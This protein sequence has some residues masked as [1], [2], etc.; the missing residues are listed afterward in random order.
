M[1]GGPEY[2][3]FAKRKKAAIGILMVAT[4]LL[5]VGDLLTGSV[6]IPFDWI[7]LAP[8]KHLFSNPKNVS[9]TG[10]IVWYLRYPRALTAAVAG[11]GLAVA[12]TVFQNILDNPLA[13]PYTIGVAHGAAFGAGLA[14]VTG[15][16]LAGLG[17]GIV[18]VNAFVFSLL[19]AGVIFGLAQFKDASSETMVLGGI[20]MSFLYGSATSLL[21]YFGTEEEAAAVVYWMFGSLTKATWTKFV[22]LASL[23]SLLFP[24]LLKWSWD[25]NALAQGD[26]VAESLGTDVRFLRIK[27]LVIGTLVTSIAVAFLGTIGFIGLAAPHIVRMAIGGEHRFLF[28]GSLLAGS[29]I[30][31][32]SDIVSRVVLSPAIIPVGII[33]SFLG[34]P[35]FGYL[36]LKRRR[37]YW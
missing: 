21:Q 29:C 37:S 2:T 33:T 22:I 14:I 12:G 3:S 10:L 26:E 36:I 5:F 4:I 19:P 1:D 31:L 28:P 34:V 15:F 7:V 11:A 24:L 20:A 25:F 30:L 6:A 35:L 18:V 8:I 13:S 27:G 9:D 23:L 32:L 16:S 17:F